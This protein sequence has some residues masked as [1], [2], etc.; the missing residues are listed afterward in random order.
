MKISKELHPS[1]ASTDRLE[2]ISLIVLQF[3]IL[4]I[5]IY[6][7]IKK[8]A[9]LLLA[10]SRNATENILLEMLERSD[11]HRAQLSSVFLL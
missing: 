11:N 4:I 1:G 10:S 2:S 8:R 9:P 7:C 6:F 5:H 3:L